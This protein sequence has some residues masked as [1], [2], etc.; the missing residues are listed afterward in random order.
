MQQ[1]PFHAYYTAR[2][3]DAAI[4]DN[5]FAP[6]F[7]S[8]GIEIYPFQ[9][10]AAS[11][12]LH[13][14][15]KGA[16][17]C[18]EAGMGKSH[19]A[20]LVMVQKWLEGCR[21][22]LL[23]IPN[24]DLLNQ[25][26]ELLNEYYTV[27]FVSIVNTND[28]NNNGKTFEQ[29]GI[30]ITTYDF[31]CEHFDEAQAVDWELT[32]FEE[33]NVLSSVYLP[34]NK[35]AKSL[36]NISKNS[37]K[38]LLTGTPIEK[39]IMDLYG[40][41]WFIDETILPNE[42]DFL[43][44]Y[45]RRPENYPELSAKVS[46]FCF[47]TLRSQ[48]RS[49]AKITDRVLLTY[50]YA[51]TSAEQEVYNKLYNYINK[52]NKIAFPE[53]DSYDLALRIL[54]L[55]SSSTAAIL[56]TVKGI[57]KRLQIN[58]N[59][60]EEL[61]KW[62]EIKHLC[63]SIETDSKLTALK[64]I[65]DSVFSANKKLGSSKK[66]VV[67]TESVETQKMLYESLNEN[68][69][70]VVYNGSKSFDAIKRFKEQAEVLIST[71]NGAKG[72]NLQDAAVV[73]HYDLPYNT[74]KIEQR[75][76]RCHRLGQQNDVLSIAFIDKNNFSDVRKLELVNKRVLVTDGVFGV[77]DN[78]IGGF[79]DNLDIDMREVL[80]T[81]R[82]KTQIEKD[83]QETLSHK[84]TVNRQALSSAEDMLFTTFTKE[85]ADKMQLT[86]KYIS[87]KAESL[88]ADLWN[89]VKY[90]FEQY[91]QNHT[92]CYFIIDDE[93]KTV[94]ASSY[95]KLPTLF[96][97]WDGSR[98]KKYTSLKS[99]GMSPNFKP[100]YGR[101]TLSSIIGRGIIHE[102]E[103]PDDGV[104]CV[105]SNMAPCSVALYNVIMSNKEKQ[106]CEMP[107]LIG[108]T[109][110]EKGLTTTECTEVLSAEVLSFSCGTHSS[111]NWLKSSSKPHK[112]DRLLDLESL[113]AQR[114][115]GFSSGTEERIRQLES[116]IKIK[117][118]ELTKQIDRMN[119]ELSELESQRDG[120]TDDRMKLLSL[121]KQINMLRQTVL[122]QEENQFFETMRLDLELEDGIK[123][124]TD[125]DKITAKAV[126]EFLINVEGES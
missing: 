2:M 7:A 32:V 93:A 105:R 89:I 5:D 3:L 27:P 10:A 122:K 111:P 67:F 61:N 66:A 71:D 55:Q 84:E 98:N 11:F 51:L 36:K 80:S 81:L 47:R 99:Y 53:M 112:I 64:K 118:A 12:A 76:D 101:I 44:R 24:A 70:V 46:K 106:L 119:A 34:D 120:I 68:Y 38:L 88:N 48:A 69:A 29:D 35:Q 65:L 60:T 97:Y 43:K 126:R 21:K 109:E 14:N 20:M 82:S 103:C 116:E 25:W 83:Y 26:L 125:A 91:N 63:E 37:F 16:I 45:L 121:D 75:I 58:S 18:D 74:L 124:I 87:D 52:P 77:S 8:S 59:A 96:Y 56:Q 54:G 19:E 4:Q 57:I 42:Q 95:E 9:I 72:F 92:E 49:Y 78:I 23:C 33:A 30:V 104:L 115:D 113:I 39:N 102:I 100:H 86:P 31:A 94:T 6:V 41:V 107:L 79:T 28:W 108:E 17:L 110:D 117:K 73:I 90:F 114:Q 85:F 50:E 13:S 22:I 40:L 62:Q 1:T 15:Q 123:E